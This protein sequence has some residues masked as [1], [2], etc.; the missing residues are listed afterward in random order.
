MS[1]QAPARLAAGSGAIAAPESG[2]VTAWP[3]S[4]LLVALLMLIEVAMAPWAVALTDT[5][6]DLLV[7]DALLDGQW[8]MRGPL[9]GNTFQLGPWWY[10]LVALPWAA[11]G[12]VTVTLVVLALLASLKYPL[13]FR[14]GSELLDRRL[15]LAFAFALAIP[16]MGSLARLDLTH[17]CMVELATLAFAYTVLRLVRGAGALWWLALGAA[18]ALALHA[19]PTTAVVLPLVLWPILVR[20]NG[21]GELAAMVAALI[22]VA[23]SLLPMLV[24]ESAE[25]WPGLQRLLDYGTGQGARLDPAGAL[26]VLALLPVNGPRLL[27]ENLAPTSIAWLVY[28]GYAL[29]A[30]AGLAGL[31]IAL[32]TGGRHRAPV[33]CALA[34]AIVIA[35]AVALLRPVTPYYMLLVFRPF[36]ALALALALHV[37]LVRPGSV[38]R[39]AGIA[40]ISAFALSASF[41]TA[42]ILRTEQGLVRLPVATI[43]DARV[44]ASRGV[45]VALAPSWRIERAARQWCG[46]APTVLH[47]Q[48]AQ[49]VGVAVG[50]LLPRRCAGSV[51]LTGGADIR[52]ARHLLGLVPAVLQRLG[53]EAGW[54]Q[55]WSLA[56]SRVV[57]GGPGLVI[58]ADRPYPYYALEA[59]APVTL[60]FDFD[61]GPE[62]FIIVATPFDVFDGATHVVLVRVEGGGPQPVPVTQPRSLQVWRCAGCAS[63]ARWQVRVSTP[64][65]ERVEVLAWRPPGAH[66]PD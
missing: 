3:W 15:G 27:A 45:E 21:P 47:G 1:R 23:V 17:T 12:S 22:V 33:L 36:A 26:R 66:A 59:R 65:P 56:P 2:G 24:A 6:R 19:H 32:R 60:G 40:L 54:Q 31:F 46:P 57:G 34:A 10:L 63:G 39:L 35:F 16:G 9:L 52:G 50:T 55:A 7:A 14:V 20:R 43:G 41:S 53:I 64:Y 38:R 29:V 44:P 49:V 30:V 8:P 28:S 62:E 25:G 5:A 48:L 37:L 4:A 13:A 11:S 51:R 58:P 42:W 61:A 18:F